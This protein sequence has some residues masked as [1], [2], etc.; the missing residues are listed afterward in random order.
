MND[1][2]CLILMGMLCGP[3][4]L[5]LVVETTGPEVRPVVSLVV[6]THASGKTTSLRTLCDVPIGPSGSSSEH[7]TKT[8]RFYRVG[9]GKHNRVMA[10]DTPG[11]TDIDEV[12]RSV[13]DRIGN[14]NGLYVCFMNASAHRPGLYEVE[15][16]EKAKHFVGRYE[17]RVAALEL[18]HADLWCGRGTV[19]SGEVETDILVVLTHVDGQT[20]AELVQLRADYA[21]VLKLQPQQII[22]RTLMLR[23][24]VLEGLFL[25]G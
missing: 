3:T 21:H 5:C 25:T 4:C 14:M 9:T 17:Y 18:P 20:D 22:V 15:T 1:H 12:S 7:G 6:G 10:I 19:Y 16:I 13:F 23:S 8:A 24:C 11:T 2:F